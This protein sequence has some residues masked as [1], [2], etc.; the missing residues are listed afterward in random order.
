MKGE[1][2]THRRLRSD[3]GRIVVEVLIEE[4]EDVPEKLGSYPSTREVV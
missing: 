4:L 2:K 1:T 3:V